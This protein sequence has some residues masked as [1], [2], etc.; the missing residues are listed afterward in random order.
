M[1]FPAQYIVVDSLRLEQVEVVV[2]ELAVLEELVS[3][4]VALGEWRFF[5]C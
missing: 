5:S 4:C 1:A 2:V 3:G